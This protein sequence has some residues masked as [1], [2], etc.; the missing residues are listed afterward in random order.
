MPPLPHLLA[1]SWREAP[2][3]S[4]GLTMDIDLTRDTCNLRGIMK[5]LVDEFPAAVESGRQE[6]WL[7]AVVSCAKMYAERNYA[8]LSESKEKK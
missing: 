3:T 6:A 1:D 8:A 4:P 2:L 5:A 7:T